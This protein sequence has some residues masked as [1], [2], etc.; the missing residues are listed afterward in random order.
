MLAKSV[1]LGKSALDMN[2]HYLELQLFLRMVQEDPSS[3]VDKGYKVFMSEER[4]YGADPAINH[5]IRKK[6]VVILYSQ[7]FQPDD[8][9]STLLYPLL[10]AGAAKMKEK[11]SNYM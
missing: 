10:A 9:D 1:T 8:W 3:V 2:T 7:L 6:S 5:R 11:L 4:L